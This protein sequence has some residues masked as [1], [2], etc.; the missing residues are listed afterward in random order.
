MPPPPGAL[1]CTPVAPCSRRHC[2]CLLAILAVAALLRLAWLDSLPPGMNQDEVIKGYDAWCLWKTAADHR[3][4]KWP[5]FL[6]SFGPGDSPSAVSAYLTAPF[7]GLLGPRVWTARL[8]IA[9]CGIATVALTW[10]WARAWLG[11]IAG[12]VAAAILA[13]N[14]WHIQISRLAFEGCLSPFF[15]MLGLCLWLRPTPTSRLSTALGGASFGIALWS[16]HAPRVAVPLLLLAAG[17]TLARH[18]I[19]SAQRT[20]WLL[21]GT[22]AGSLPLWLTIMDQPSRVFG[23]AGEVALFR[24]AET[25]GADLLQFARQ[26]VAHFDP[27]VLFLT[28]DGRLNQSAPYVGMLHWSEAPL[29]LIGLFALIRRARHD[30]MARFL[31][32]WGLIY[33]LAPS[34]ARDGGPHIVR[35]AVG[36]P[37]PVLVEAVGLLAAFDLLAAR[38]ARTRKWAVSV[39]LSLATVSSAWFARHYFMEFPKTAEAAFQ[40]ELPAAFRWIAAHAEPYDAAALA[41]PAHQAFVYYLYFTPVDPPAAQSATVRREPWVLGFEQLL[42]LDRWRFCPPTLRNGWTNHDIDTLA[43]SLAPLRRLL[44]LSRPHQG[45]DGRLRHVIRNSANQPVLLILERDEIAQ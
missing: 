32:A 14:P 44:I 26:Y 2:A 7:V 45:I 37:W 28:G 11:A 29:L 36:L 8:P 34:L 17:L 43:S 21:L 6:A 19:P 5:A 39:V 30:A 3:G 41:F 40:A 27:G 1:P 13:L 10:C 25:V 4:T 31:L 38:H 22:L 16:Y 18:R 20:R 33:P 35:D 23:R 24:S 9:L 15:V 42:Q 12:L